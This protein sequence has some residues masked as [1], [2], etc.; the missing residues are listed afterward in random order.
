MNQFLNSLNKIQ[1][2]NT[3]QVFVP[4]LLVFAMLFSFISHGEHYNL[5]KGDVSNIAAEQHC[6]LCQQYIDDIDNNIG[7][8]Q[9]F[10]S[11][12]SAYVPHV[13]PITFHANN[14]VTPPLRAPPVYS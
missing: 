13:Y 10:I 5:A 11:R 12:Y 3:R 8:S 4:A 2:I 6:S 14:S 1:R 7:I 9:Q